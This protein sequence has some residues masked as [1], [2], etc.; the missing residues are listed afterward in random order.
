MDLYTPQS[1]NALFCPAPCSPCESVCGLCVDELCGGCLSSHGGNLSRV[2]LSRMCHG[3]SILGNS[4]TKESLKI[5][6]C[7]ESGMCVWLWQ[8]GG[9]WIAFQHGDMSCAHPWSCSLPS[10]HPICRGHPTLTLWRAPDC[11]K[12]GHGTVYV[13]PH[14][15]TMS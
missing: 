1:I 3:V 2:L 10:P 6:V 12:H 8:G 14:L 7:I 4:C 13:T 15:L 5:A 9:G 11:L